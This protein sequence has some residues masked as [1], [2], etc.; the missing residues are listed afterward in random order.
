M[1][2]YSIFSHF[3]LFQ[4]VLEN[5]PQ[6]LSCQKLIDLN[7]GVHWYSMKFGPVQHTNIHELYKDRAYFDEETNLVFR[8]FAL[9]D[10]D[11]Y[12]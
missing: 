10:D 3:F 6:V 1:N 7:A 5:D 4:L 8:K 2:L 11:E 12:L 9:E